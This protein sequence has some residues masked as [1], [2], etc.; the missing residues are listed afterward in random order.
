MESSLILSGKK[1]ISARR[2][3]EIAGYS[4]DYVGQLC[5]LG[6]IEAQMVGKVWFVCEESLLTHKIT[7]ERL[8]EEMRQR[9]SERRGVSELV[10]VE[11]KEVTET[12]P[13]LPVCSPFAL[14]VS[15]VQPHV[16]AMYNG[17]LLWMLAGCFIFTIIA[18]GMDVQN[19]SLG[20]PLR[21]QITSFVSHAKDSVLVTIFRAQEK[22]VASAHDSLNTLTLTVDNVIASTEEKIISTDAQVRLA[23][24][25][26]GAE[27][28]SFGVSVTDRVTTAYADAVSGTLALAD[29]FVTS[30]RFA[31]ESAT[32]VVALAYERTTSSIISSMTSLTS[33]ASLLLPQTNSFVSSVAKS[34]DITKYV[35]SKDFAF[36]TPVVSVADVSDV[37]QT[38]AQLQGEIV[39][40]GVLSAPQKNTPSSRA[41]LMFGAIQSDFASVQGMFLSGVTF[42]SEGIATLVAKTTSGILALNGWYQRHTDA[43][44][45]RSVRT[46]QFF[47]SLSDVTLVEARNTGRV[48]SSVATS[49]IGAVQNIGKNVASNFVSVSEATA[50]S[51]ISLG[52]SIAYSV[53]TVQTAGNTLSATVSESST[54]FG[55]SLGDALT[56]AGSGVK[57]LALHTYDFARS[58]L[59]PETYLSRLSQLFG[60]NKSLTV[61]EAPVTE[62]VSLPQSTSL[63]IAVVPKT[64]GQSAAAIKRQIQDSFS[65]EVEVHPDDSGT[66][67]IIKPVFRKITS[68]EYV[69]VLV[70][71][72][73]Q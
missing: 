40:N 57:T 32:D 10:V 31:R 52:E 24:V 63:G 37:S 73:Q 21:E 33:L 29:T 60:E 9:M 12:T 58:L 67:G 22:A 39:L 70:P 48:I 36:S 13:S 4:G 69:Y 41:T 15:N 16:Q 30:L 23:S 43:V 3:A 18:S 2:G 50:S 38:L 8:N 53:Q 7:Q 19:I 6:K 46:T 61:V 20:N 72:K 49:M 71:V 59:V 34:V 56:R 25:N 64:V 27:I 1:F 45:A 42:T 51:V 26:A 14:T 62:S 68:D 55:Q 28:I 11:A 54:S 65:D 66:S 35:S 17:K 5:R 44:I 47:S